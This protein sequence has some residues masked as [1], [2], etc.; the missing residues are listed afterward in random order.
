MNI[1]KNETFSVYKNCIILKDFDT[2]KQGQ[3]YE[4]I[5]INIT[6]HGWNEEYSDEEANACI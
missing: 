1:E 3:T 6:L 4:I 2:F 5:T